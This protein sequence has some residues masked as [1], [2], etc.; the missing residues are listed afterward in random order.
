MAEIRDFDLKKLGEVKVPAARGIKITPDGKMEFV[1]GDFVTAEHAEQLTA[2][3]GA[4]GKG[5]SPVTI[6]RI[7]G[8]KTDTQ[9]YLLVRDQQKGSWKSAKA[10]SFKSVVTHIADAM[11]GKGPRKVK[12]AKQIKLNDPKA[13]A[14]AAASLDD[15]TRAALLAALGVGA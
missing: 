12:V 2:P 3:A 11:A 8:G 6:R 13:M 1:D 14:K 10:V 7:A 15:E 5:L 4:G 9:V